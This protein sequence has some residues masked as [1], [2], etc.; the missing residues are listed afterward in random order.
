MYSNEHNFINNVLLVAKEYFNLKLSN[1]TKRANFYGLVLFPRVG[2]I[3]FLAMY[4]FVIV[5]TRLCGQRNTSP[6]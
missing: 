3:V 2:P 1:V 4:T 6:K 5:T